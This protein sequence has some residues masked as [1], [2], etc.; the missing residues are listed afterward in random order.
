MT[1][2]TPTPSGD[3]SLEVTI[4]RK[5]SLAVVFVLLVQM[6]GGVWAISE[7]YHSQQELQNNF[8]DSV[9]TLT[10][11]INDLKSTIYTR[12]EATLRFDAIQQ[13]NRRQDQEI[14][15]LRSKLYG[16]NN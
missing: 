3:L 13:D 6:F 7:F 5:I 14:Q 8:K 2:P 16:R 12:S 4:P 1:T 15:E 11:Q 9:T 10:T